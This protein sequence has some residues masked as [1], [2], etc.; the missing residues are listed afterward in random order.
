MRLGRALA[1]IG[2]TLAALAL[3]ACGGDESGDAAPPGR[4]AVLAPPERPPSPGGASTAPLPGST[5]SDATEGPLVLA[6]RPGP[7]GGR[8]A[9]GIHRFA[10]R[11]HS[12]TLRVSERRGSGPR[13]LLLALHG[14]GGGSEDALWA[15]R[16]AWNRPGMVIV[17]P[18]SEGRSWSLDADLRAIDAA[19]ARAFARCRIDP[20]RVAVGGFSAGATLAVQLGLA[21]GGLFHAVAALSPS[22]SLPPTRRGQPRVF[23][24]HGRNDEVIPID[25]GGA[26]LVEELR[27]D[28][29]DV[30][31]RRFPGGHA[32]PKPVSKAAADWLLR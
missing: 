13:P 12:I 5:G 28:D 8:C 23:V 9:P 26:A 27:T 22:A 2:L 29:Y 20:E 6:A 1:P 25:R 10:L 31:F 17:A 11:G 21:N 32:V 15:F 3:A 4:D 14:A 30:T 19:L 24:A 7:G 16:A 18:E